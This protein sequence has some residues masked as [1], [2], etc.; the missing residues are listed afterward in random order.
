M[1][2]LQDNGTHYINEQTLKGIGLCL[3]FMMEPI[4]QFLPMA[5]LL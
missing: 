3:L 2:G 4:V 1:G 5:N